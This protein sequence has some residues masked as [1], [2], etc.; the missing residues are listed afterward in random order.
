MIILKCTKKIPHIGD[1]DSL[2]RCRQQHQYYR[3]PLFLKT[4][5][6]TLQPS[7]E[8]FF[9]TIWVSLSLLAIFVKYENQNHLCCVTCHVYQVTCHVSRVT[10]HML[11]VIHQLPPVTNANRHSNR[12]FPA[13]S[14]TIRSRLLPDS[15]KLFKKFVG[16]LGTFPKPQIS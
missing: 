12:A 3:I 5:L 11:H 16:L 14:Q 7:L 15:K 10:C 2:D 8:L 9:V 4:L 13:Y 6:L 1:T